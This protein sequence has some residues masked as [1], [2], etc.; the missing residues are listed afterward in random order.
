[1]VHSSTLDPE[2]EVAAQPLELTPFERS[3]VHGI[4]PAV[5]ALK[6]ACQ[7]VTHDA[8]AVYLCR[9]LPE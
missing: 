7:P 3:M 1:M 5:H 2:R 8:V 9:N 6:Q 4:A